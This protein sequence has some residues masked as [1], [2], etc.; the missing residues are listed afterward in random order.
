MQRLLS[1]EFSSLRSEQLPSDPPVAM[2]LKD[3]RVKNVLI[4]SCFLY[5]Y[6]TTATAETVFI[7]LSFF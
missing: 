1:P 7:V 2:A 4:S 3:I 6:N 5:S